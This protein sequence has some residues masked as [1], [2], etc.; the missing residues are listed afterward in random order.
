M[1]EYAVIVFLICVVVYLY[2]NQDNKQDGL[3]VYWFH[4][5]GCPHC[6]NMESA[7]SGVEGHTWGP[8]IQVKRVDTSKPEHSKLS[9]NFNITG[10]PQII[11]V[12][13]DGMRYIYEGKRTTKKIIDWI[14]E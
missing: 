14:E 8:N 5:P 3:K 9:T 4:R 2:S 1:R 13:S 12:R 10:V 11:K 7:W 6:D